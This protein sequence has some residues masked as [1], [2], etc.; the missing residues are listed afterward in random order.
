M[1]KSMS[2]YFSETMKMDGEEGPVKP[3]VNGSHE[4]ATTEEKAGEET[5]EEGSKSDKEIVLIQDTGFNVQI[6]IPGGSPI[7][8][9]VR[10]L[11][12]L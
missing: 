2:F 12:S 9:P 5:G 6:Q 7:E 4:V 8:L 11:S 1:M 10:P 3:L